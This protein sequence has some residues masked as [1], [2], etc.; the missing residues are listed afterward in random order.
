MPAFSAKI[1]IQEQWFDTTAPG[2]HQEALIPL[3]SETHSG[4][5]IGIYATGPGASAVIGTNEQNVV[6]HVINAALG[7]E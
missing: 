2:F 6:F 3:S 1:S 7:L 5:D 4:E